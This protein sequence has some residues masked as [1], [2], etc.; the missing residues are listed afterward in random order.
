MVVWNFNELD[1]WLWPT[2]LQFWVPDDTALCFENLAN[3]SVFKMKGISVG[4]REKTQT[5][6]AT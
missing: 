1:K 5:V 4:E 3:Q 6:G 2:F